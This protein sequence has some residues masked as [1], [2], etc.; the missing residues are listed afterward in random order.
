MGTPVDVSPS[1]QPS[2]PRQDE[3]GLRIRVDSWVGLV[4][5]AGEL[6]REHSP[7]LLAALSTL[8]ETH[9]RTWL[10]DTAGVTFCDAGGLRALVAAERLA[11]DHGCQLTVIRSSQCV[12]R[13][14][15]LVGLTRLLQPHTPR[16]IE[17]PTVSTASDRDPVPVP[18]PAR[19]ESMS[20]ATI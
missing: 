9:H 1:P 10:V 19:A 2:L 3:P 5:V 11:A 13:L 7:E 16:R 20:R 4:L 15:T 17:H 6:D 12:H 8:A 14:V 18:V